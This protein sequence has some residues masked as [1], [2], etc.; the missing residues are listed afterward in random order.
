M[1]AKENYLRAVEM[2]EPE[3]IP[4]A[5]S[6]SPPLWHK[7]RER[8]EDLVLRRPMIFGEYRKGSR[9]FDDFG[10]RRKGNTVTDEWGCVWQFLVDGLQGQ[11]MKHPIEDW[12]AL[13]SYEAPDPLLLNNVQEEGAPPS[14]N[15]FDKARNDVEEDRKEGNLTVGHCSHGFMFQRLY[16][17]RGFSNLMK[18][19]ASEPPELK[20]LIDI[21]LGYN[22][23]VI[24]RWLDVGVEVLVFGDDLGMQDR[25]PIHP[26]KFRKYMVPAYSRMF[27]PAR[28][29][30]VHVF[31][32]SDGHIMEVADDLIGAGVSILNLQDLVNGV[33]NIRGRL[34]GK[35]CIDL[36]IDRQRIVPFGTPQEVKR[37]IRRVVSALNSPEGGFMMTAG[38]YPPTPLGNIEALCEAMEEAGGGPRF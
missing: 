35:V 29:K 32:H 20:R 31:L 21:V 7:Y 1:D 16:Y 36:D 5:V 8:M 14:V 6:I 18:D 17:L 26:E 4:C 33:D 22:M 12:E 27:M 37:H 30:G 2:R 24:R 34:K 13:D 3:W 11:V 10:I 25:L 15:S 28:E 23:K 38:I 9:D 19:F